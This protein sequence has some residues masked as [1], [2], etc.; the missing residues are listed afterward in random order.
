MIG[1]AIG[2]AIGSR[3]ESNLNNVNR[4]IKDIEML[5]TNGI[6]C[7]KP[8]QWTDDTSMGLCIA[9]SLIENRQFDPRNIMARFI[10]YRFYK[11]KHSV[12]IGRNVF[13]SFKKYIYDKG[14]DNYTKNGNKNISGIGSI[15]RNAAIPI[16][17]F[18]NLKHALICSE[19]QSLITHQGYEAAGCCQLLTYIIIKILNKKSPKNQEYN[20]YKTN[21]NNE[22]SILEQEKLKDI[23]DNLE[24]F[25]CA[26]PSVNYLAQS[27]KEGKDKKR[28]WNWKDVNFK[29][30]EE[31]EK[32]QPD[33]ISSYCMDCLSMALHILYHTYNF[34]D[35]ILKAANLGGNA[36]SLC[37]VVGQIAGAYYGLDSIPG[38][39]IKTINMWS[40]GEIALRGYILCN[41]EK[42][43]F[44]KCIFK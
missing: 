30:N 43:Y 23:L 3:V 10:L 6:N 11:N 20:K 18:R 38:D 8:G 42:V 28:N 44:K 14:K 16:C 25:F 19:L 15:A 7:L 31:K 22:S 2:D 24:E 29:Y 17:Y 34:K 36:S 27:L 4:E 1:M 40:N 5:L 12:G 41:L 13:E 9:D 33:K 26:Y 32:I 37:S 21:I 35:A 39:W